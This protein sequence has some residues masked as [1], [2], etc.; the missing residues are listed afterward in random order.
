MVKKGEKKLAKN[1]NTELAS[2]LEALKTHI[3]ALK[4]QKLN[5]ITNALTQ[6]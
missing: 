5:I 3:A 6:S 4:A 1:S 2:F